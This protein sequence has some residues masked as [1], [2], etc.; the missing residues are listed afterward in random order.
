MVEGT[1]AP[2]FLT[3]LCQSTTISAPIKLLLRMRR[4]HTKRC[5][6]VDATVRI[7]PRNNFSAPAVLYRVRELL[8]APLDATV[9]V[10]DGEKHVATLRARLG[11][12]NTDKLPDAVTTNPCGCLRGWHSAYSARLPNRNM[13]TLPDNDRRSKHTLRSCSLLCRASHSQ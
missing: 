8:A 11:L 10:V 1:V 13:I 7:L 6:L 4:H 5:E 12:D 2:T 3:P 9:I